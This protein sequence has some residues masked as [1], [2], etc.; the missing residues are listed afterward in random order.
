M[1]RQMMVR[2]ARPAAQVAPRRG[3]A[4]HGHA[5]EVLP[6]DFKAAVPA[7]PSDTAFFGKTVGGAPSPQTFQTA[8]LASSVAAAALRGAAPR[9]LE[10]REPGE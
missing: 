6:G 4:G 1:M 9:R 5:I 2:A 7:A 10:A 8:R 3:F